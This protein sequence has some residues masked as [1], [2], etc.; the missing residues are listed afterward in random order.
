[1]KATDFKMYGNPIVPENASGELKETYNELEKMFNSIMPHIQL[2]AT[3][4]L[5]DMKCFT[6]PMKLSRNHPEIPL[7]WFALMRLYVSFKDD[8]PYCKVLNIKMLQDLGMKDTDINRY[9]D[10]IDEAPI[11]KKLI[12]LL[13]KAIKSIYDSHNFKQKDFEELYQAGFSDKT[14][15]QA[16]TY[17]MGFAG[18]A[19][20]LNTYIVK[21]SFTA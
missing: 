7:I 6:D 16:V 21:E 19:R 13:K 9:L 11:D 18:I 4:A 3:Y 17:S 1:M 14:I 20:R 12:L 2:H 5:E 15:Y 10:N 8:F